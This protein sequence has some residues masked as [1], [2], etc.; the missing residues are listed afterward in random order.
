VTAR[1]PK[2]SRKNYFSV[3]E[4]YFSG[5]EIVFGGAERPFGGDEKSPKITSKACFYTKKALS[6]RGIFRV[7]RKYHA[8]FHTYTTFFSYLCREISD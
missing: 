2:R 6:A 1:P 4:H 3:V 8:P 7:L 5:A